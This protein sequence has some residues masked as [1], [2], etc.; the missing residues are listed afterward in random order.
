MTPLTRMYTI[1]PIKFKYRIR[2]K[3]NKEKNQ[4]QIKENLNI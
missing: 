4:D 2:I 3:E 1:L